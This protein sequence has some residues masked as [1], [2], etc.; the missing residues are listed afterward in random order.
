M[1]EESLLD[2]FCPVEAWLAEHK[3][4]MPAFV[5][6]LCGDV[7]RTFHGSTWARGGPGILR[8][9]SSRGGFA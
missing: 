4:G 8:Q 7:T 1:P 9:R 3:R 6:N 2:R 5:Q